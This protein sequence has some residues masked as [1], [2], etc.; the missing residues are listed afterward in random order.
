MAKKQASI[1]TMHRPHLTPAQV[2]LQER[3]RPSFPCQYCAD[4]GRTETTEWLLEAPTDGADT[5]WF[6]C[7]RCGKYVFVPQEPRP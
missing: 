4:H 5:L 3:Y 6:Y 2:T 7:T 1:Q